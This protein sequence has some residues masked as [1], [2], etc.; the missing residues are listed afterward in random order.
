MQIPLLLLQ[1]LG[2]RLIQGCLWKE[3]PGRGLSS[4]KP[5]WGFFP[6]ISCQGG[7][8]PFR[9]G[10]LVFSLISLLL[11]QLCPPSQAS[12]LPSMDLLFSAFP[13]LLV[14]PALVPLI[15]VGSFSL[16]CPPGLVFRIPV[17]VH[18]LRPSPVNL[19]PVSL[20]VSPPPLLMGGAV[21]HL[22]SSPRTP[23]A[24]CPQ[25]SPSLGELSAQT[26]PLSLPTALLTFN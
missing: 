16:F 25:S 6:L 23:G 2:V 3:S 20:S 24:P 12:I 15:L 22:L 4:W 10:S 18:D 26:P 21:S 11:L 5:T 1:D 8:S 7:E 14:S 9:A 13:V 19:S 17:L